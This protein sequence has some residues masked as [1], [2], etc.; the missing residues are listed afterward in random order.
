MKNVVSH[1]GVFH[2]DDVFAVAIVQRAV[3]DIQI[4]RTRDQTKMDVA[5]FVVDVGGKSDGERFFDHHQKGGAGTRENGFPYASAGLVW[6][7][8][9]AEICGSKDVADKVDLDLIQFIDGADCGFGTKP[10]AQTASDIISSMN[11]R[12]YE[13]PDFDGAFTKAVMMATSILERDIA[14]A[15]GETLA[16][17]EV[18]AALAKREKAE[19]LVL[20]RFAPWHETVLTKAPE[21]LYVIFPAAGDARQWN[22]QCVPVSKES[23]EKKKALPASWAGKR[24]A[25]LAAETGVEDAVFCHVG[26]FIA[27]AGS[28]AGVVKMAE[29]ALL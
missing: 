27:G 12:W 28:K 3:G 8:F 25:E 29:A 4:I 26:L 9:G 21:V 6:K 17:I 15:K 10:D 22:V 11:P 16:K 1:N 19:I 2:A 13:T 5:D 18:E 24:G 7:K 23:F 14:R 20:E